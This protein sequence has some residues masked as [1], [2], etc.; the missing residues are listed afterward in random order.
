MQPPL[1]CSLPGVGPSTQGLETPLL[2]PYGPVLQANPGAKW[3]LESDLD[4]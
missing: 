2:S 1:N 4:V 3:R